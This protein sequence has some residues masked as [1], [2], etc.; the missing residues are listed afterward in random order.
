MAIQMKKGVLHANCKPKTSKNLPFMRSY[1][2]KVAS[3]SITYVVM[4]TVS[5][6]SS[7]FLFLFLLFFLFVIFMCRFLYVPPLQ[8]LGGSGIPRFLHSFPCPASRN[9]T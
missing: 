2:S 8:A 7:G 4:Y 3:F 6:S 1:N 5:L 9:Y